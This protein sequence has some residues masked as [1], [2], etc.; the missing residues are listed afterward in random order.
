DIVQES[1]GFTDAAIS[2]TGGTLDLGTTASPGNNT[3]N[4]NGTGQ[5]VQNSTASAISAVGDAFESNG[6]VLPAPLLS[7][8]S[9]TASVNPSTLNQSV[10]LT[11]SVRPN[12]STATPTGRVDFFDTT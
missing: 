5:F 12:G 9:L 4:V 8:T 10:T 2:I 7:F 3:I 11:A 1:T 6:T